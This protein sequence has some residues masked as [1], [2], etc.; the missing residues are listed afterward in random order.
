MQKKTDWYTHDRFGLF[1]HWGI[2]AIPGRGEWVRYYEDLSNEDYEPFFKEFNP[3]EYDPVIWAKAAKNAG[4]KYAVMTTKHHD[5][6]CLFDSKY[7]DFKS[8][9]TPCGRDLIKEYTDAFRNEGIKIGFYYS[10]LDWHHPGFP[11]YGDDSHPMRKNEAFKD[12]THDFDSYLTYMHNQVEEL[13]TN[14]GKIDIFWFDY[15]Y[16]HMAGETW[17]AT[18]LVRMV[19]KYHPD[20]LFDNRLTKKT[21]IL[22]EN[23]EEYSGDFYSPELT[24]PYDPYGVRNEK[25]EPIPWETCTTINNSW[26]YTQDKS[27]K[28]AS[29]IIK[30]LVECVSKGGNLLLNVG[31]DAKGNFPEEALKTLEGVG[32]WMKKNGKSIYGC[33]YSEMEKPDFGRITK[34]KCGRYLYYH[35][36][37]NPLGAIPIA[38]VKKE[39]IKKMRLISDGTEI[40]I[41]DAWVTQ[42]YPEL[43]LITLGTGYLLPDE[44]DTVIEVE[45]CE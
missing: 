37:E 34:S 30:K 6:F 35:I 23:P 8:T 25:G 36:M 15:S 14:Y 26:S 2:Y 5:G 19:R 17:K 12:I 22:S 42:F 10:L 31:P 29:Y 32:R 20:V 33:G 16:G 41:S 18:E 44:T 28:S 40:K 24:I 38:G 45:L 7:T 21:S 43:A 13:C 39:Q 3:T 1:I 27:F 4:M 11:H 9:N